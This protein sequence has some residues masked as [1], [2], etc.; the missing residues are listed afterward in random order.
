MFEYEIGDVIQCG[1]SIVRIH[2]IDGELAWYHGTELG[3]ASHGGVVLGW[4]LARG[5][6]PILRRAGKAISSASELPYQ[7]AV[8]LFPDEPWLRQPGCVGDRLKH[9]L[10]REAGIASL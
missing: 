9:W 1:T 4:C 8:K 3:E 10:G 6:W 2:R 7:Q 5:E